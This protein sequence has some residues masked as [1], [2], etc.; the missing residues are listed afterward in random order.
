[1]ESI[2]EATL[3]AQG[4]EYQR[5]FYCPQPFDNRPWIGM[6]EAGNKLWIGRYSLL[7]QDRHI[8]FRR[9]ENSRLIKLIRED[10]VIP[11]GLL[12]KTLSDTVSCSR[13]DVAA[14]LQLAA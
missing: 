9:V 1:M 8:S 6:A 11:R 14:D 4:N 5:Y 10:L 12:L 2:F 13:T 7:D 3:H